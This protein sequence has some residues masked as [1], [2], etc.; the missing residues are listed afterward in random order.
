MR[1]E[2]G[3]NYWTININ[4]SGNFYAQ[5]VME[6]QWPIDDSL[7]KNKLYFLTEEQAQTIIEILRDRLS[8]GADGA[9]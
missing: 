7:Y 4:S 9:Q 2:K 3:E 6:K 1:A 8:A 5:S